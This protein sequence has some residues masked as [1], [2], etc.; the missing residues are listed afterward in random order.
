MSQATLVRWGNGQGVRLARQVVE[1]ANLHVGERLDVRV[2]A[3]GR[4]VITALPSEEDIEL[5]DFEAL[6]ASYEGG[7]VHEDDA[8]RPV[9]GELL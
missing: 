3:R 1:D 9:G 5:P 7:P 2:D 6:F 8:A 4:I